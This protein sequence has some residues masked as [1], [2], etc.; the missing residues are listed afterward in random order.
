MYEYNQKMLYRVYA[1]FC[2]VLVCFALYV[3]C[4]CR[5][6]S[7]LQSS[8]DREIGALKEQQRQ[9]GAEISRA[10]D[11]VESAEKALDRAGQRAAA[12]QEGLGECEA[13]VKECQRLAEENADILGSLGAE[14]R[15]GK[16][17]SGKN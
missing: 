9:A 3:G 11:E 7:G 10:G 17:T 2:L 5:Y 4:A 12:V 8:T 16:K 6:P 13:I 15:A 1:C 14:A